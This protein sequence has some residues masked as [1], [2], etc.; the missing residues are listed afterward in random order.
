[1]NWIAP[2][3]CCSGLAIGARDRELVGIGGLICTVDG[4]VNSV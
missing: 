2:P 1:M 4:L 3:M